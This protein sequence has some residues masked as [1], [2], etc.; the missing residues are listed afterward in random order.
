[1]SIIT[2][3]GK[4]SGYTLKGYEDY[5]PEPEDFHLDEFQQSFIVVYVVCTLI[6]RPDA[7]PVLCIFSMVIAILPRK[8]RHVRV[9]TTVS[10]LFC[11]QTGFRSNGS[12]IFMSEKPT[13]GPETTTICQKVYERKVREWTEKQQ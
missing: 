8:D 5:V 6:P 9:N 12:P 4:H 2:C 10:G 3:G 11:A 1:M 13:S 7:K